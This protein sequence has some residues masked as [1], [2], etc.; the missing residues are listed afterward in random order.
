MLRFSI[1]ILCLPLCCLVLNII[2]VFAIST[3]YSLSL[4]LRLSHTSINASLSPNSITPTL[5]Q[6]PRP[7]PDK[8]TDFVTQIMKVHNTNYL[9]DF[10]NL[11]RG[12]SRFVSANFVADFVADFSRVFLTD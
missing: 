5:R 1:G 7:V 3:V 9:A 6:S 2:V 4:C 12:L 11:C 8:I 10:H